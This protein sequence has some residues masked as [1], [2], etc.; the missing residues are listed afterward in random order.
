MSKKLEPFKKAKHK[1][2]ADI[3]RVDIPSGAN[4]AVGRLNHLWASYCYIPTQPKKEATERLRKENR[5][6][7]RL[8]ILAVSEAIRRCKAQLKRKNLSQK[9]RGEFKQ[10]VKIYSE[11]LKK[12]RLK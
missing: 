10:I 9:E 2:L 4:E 5:E 8:L 1:W 12:H 3:I 11:W 7:K 6:K